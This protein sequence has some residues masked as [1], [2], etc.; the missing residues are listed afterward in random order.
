M[1]KTRIKFWPYEIGA[2]DIFEEDVVI[3]PW[4]R[5]EP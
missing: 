2:L 1:V 5:G 3:A 4:G